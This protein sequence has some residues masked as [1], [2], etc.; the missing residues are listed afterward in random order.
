MYWGAAKRYTREHCNYTWNGLQKTV[1]E[2]LNS[3]S[4]IEIKCFFSNISVNIDA[5]NANLLSLDSSRRDESNEPKYVKFQ[6]QDRL[7]TG[8]GSIRKFENTPVIRNSGQNLHINST[9]TQM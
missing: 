5:K 1:P 2:A 6:S 3:I 8:L 7:K 4:L 9:Q